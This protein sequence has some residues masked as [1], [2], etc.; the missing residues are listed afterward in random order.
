MEKFC[1]ICKKC[2]DN[3]P[4][5]SISE[6]DE[7]PINSRGIKLW[8]IDQEKCFSYWKTI[9]TDCGICIR[10]CPYTKPN[11]FIHKL[12][13][14]YISRNPINQRIALLMDDLFYSRKIKIPKV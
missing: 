9:G 10:V 5:L 2:A 6:E 7:E 14:S 1:L 12:V 3:C 4:T 11:T 8:S 13:R